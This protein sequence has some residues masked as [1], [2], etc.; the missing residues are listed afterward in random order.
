MS[1]ANFDSDTT[2][3]MAA[4]AVLYRLGEDEIEIGLIHRPR[5][6]DWSFPKGKIEF[7]ESF[8]QLPTGKYWKRPDMRPNSAH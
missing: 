8:W 3:I 1:K 2:E 5:Y 4:G 7:G 6:D